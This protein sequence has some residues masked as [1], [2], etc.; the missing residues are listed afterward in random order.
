M[1]RAEPAC[2]TRKACVR[3]R[4]HLHALRCGSRLQ[5]CGPLAERKLYPRDGRE[6]FMPARIVG[7][8]AGV[9]KEVGRGAVHGEIAVV[10]S[11]VH[12]SSVSPVSAAYAHSTVEAV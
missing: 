9:E 3:G 2:E 5:Q 4:K 7:S 11:Q 8:R 12:R 6:V 10:R 1:R